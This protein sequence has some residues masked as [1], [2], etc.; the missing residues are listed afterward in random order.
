MDN[1]YALNPYHSSKKEVTHISLFSSNLDLFKQLKEWF[2]VTSYRFSTVTSQEEL[3]ERGV[4][5]EILL[6]DTRFQSPE[7][8]PL[9]RRIKDA[10]PEL[11]ILACLSKEEQGLGHTVVA[12]GADDFILDSELQDL[13]PRFIR[14]SLEKRNLRRD[15]SETR[16]LLNM[17]LVRKG[18]QEENF[19]TVLREVLE[20][21]TQNHRDVI[22]N[23]SRI[24]S[25]SQDLDQLI[26][27]ALMVLKDYFHVSR[28]GLFLDE[29]GVGSFVLRGGVGIP[30][31]Q[32]EKVM[33]RHSVLVSSLANQGTILYRTGSNSV[34]SGSQPLEVQRELD[35]L[36]CEVAVPLFVKGKLVG[37]LVCNNKVSGTPLTE[38]DLTFLFS[39]CGQIAIAVENARL[40]SVLSVQK[41]YLDS[42][43][44]NVLSG[45]ITVDNK[46]E[47]KTFNPKAEE[48]LGI[49]ANDALFQNF[50]IL[51][52][53]FS[54]VL[55]ETLI[56]G[57]SFHRHEVTLPNSDRPIGI[58]TSQ[59]KGNKGETLGCVI[60]FA[61]L[62]DIQKQRE[63]SR[64]QD[65][66]KFVNKVAMRSS[67]ELKNCL[68]S[69]RTFTQLLPDK[70]SDEQFRTDFYAIVNHEV[71]R[72]T[73]LVD[74]LNFFAQNLELYR[75]P[76][77][78]DRIFDD[79]IA[80]IPA[81]ERENVAFTKEFDL[82]GI[83]MELDTENMKKV[84]YNC[85]R[86][87][88]QAMDDGGQVD[89]RVKKENQKVFGSSKEKVDFIRIEF[90]DNGNGMPVEELERAFEPFF[91]TNNR[92]IGLGL[93]IVKKI[94]DAHLGSVQIDSEVGKG[95]TVTVIVPNKSNA[96]LES[97]QEKKT[98]HSNESTPQNTNS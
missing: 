76:I 54:D 32:F 42:V 60:V 68:V 7:G 37:F 46:E 77:G 79:A 71:D 35:N 96:E 94:V 73:V 49:G 12:L 30:D 13:L 8:L 45:V 33:S 40:Y 28:M 48:I 55:R 10:H 2:G 63:W 58:S 62:T 56:D 91:T 78:L 17:E 69:I 64:H 88:V 74:N 29:L 14:R 51:P 43:L 3:I 9:I 82:E 5:G 59:L 34:A 16:Q 70:Y 52:S 57:K 50:R 75:V 4:L 72:L 90:H 66:M 93:T 84:F 83:T 31:E 98:L 95:T 6:L 20:P 11:P 23:F 38:S 92:G 89:V 26:P 87:A 97:A 85:F 39:L 18:S 44:T 27:L 1:P 36:Q 19:K 80:M 25:A 65:H 61:D 24:L 81:E 22:K 86:N 41:R 67:H 15:L 21:K 53:P 47:I